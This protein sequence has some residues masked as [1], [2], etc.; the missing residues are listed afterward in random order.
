MRR[1]ARPAGIRPRSEDRAGVEDAV[2]VERGLDP[3]HQVDLDRVLE[4]EEVLAASPCRC[5]ARP[6]SR[7][8]APCPPR[9]ARAARFDALVG[10]GLGTPRGA[11]CR[12]RRGRSR[13]RT[14]RS[15]RRCRRRAAMYSAID[16]RGTTTS[17]MSSAPAAFATQNAF[18]RASI[19]CWPRR[20]RQHV[21]VDGAELG[22]QLG[23]LAARPR[24]AG[25]RCGSPARRRGRRASA[26]CTSSGTPSSRPT[27]RVDARPWSARSMYSRI[28][29]PTPLADDP[30]HR[31]H[32]L[33][34]RGER[35]EHGRLV[36]R[37]AGRACSVASVTSASVPSEP[38]IE[39]REVVAGRRL[40]ELAAG[41]D[42]LAGRRAPP[43]G[44]APGG[45]SRR[46]SRP[47]CRPRSWRRC[48][49]G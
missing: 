25:R 38:M 4:L 34:E 20:G 1:R 26:R 39:L 42:D 5:R 16:A 15:P 11:R 28:S 21:H 36:L 7:R 3:A 48:R 13:R 10:V 17:M 2:R 47:A 8:R 22:Q 31:V 49:R 40:H 32:H 33:V 35:R 14:C 30:R 24:R 9:T 23:E 12:R 27:S 46:T 37:A 44:R 45:G 18:S 29:G 41:A 19:S 6:R 43:R